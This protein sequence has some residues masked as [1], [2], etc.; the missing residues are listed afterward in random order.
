LRPHQRKP[1][2]VDK[3]LGA[4]E[5][6]E[7]NLSLLSVEKLADQLGLSALDLLKQAISRGAS[8]SADSP[9]RRYA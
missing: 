5:R 9:A 6:G 4:V 8:L 7:R 3:Y 2:N 1:P